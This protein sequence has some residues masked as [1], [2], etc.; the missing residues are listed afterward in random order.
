MD[1]FAWDNIDVIGI[2]K[3]NPHITAPS[4]ENREK[5]I[6][7]VA[8]K[9]R[10]SLN[11]IWSFCFSKNPLSSPTSF[12][13]TDYDVS[14]WETISVPSNWEFKGYGIPI[15]TNVKYPNSIS[16]KKIPSIDH[17]DNPTGCYKRKFNIPIEWIGRKLFINFD[18]VKSAFYLWING[19]E[20]GYS[21]GSMTPSEFDIT[22]YIHE[23]ENDVS[24]E[25]FKYCD[26][27]YL[28]DQ[29]M[30]RLSGIFRD[31]YLSSKPTTE[32]WDVY[33]HSDLDSD[34]K[35]AVLYIDTKI[36]NYCEATNSKIILNIELLDDSF[37]L[38]EKYLVEDVSINNN[39]QN[40]MIQ[41]KVNNPHKWSHEKPYLYNILFE[42][43]NSNGEVIDLKAIKF[44][45]RKI[46]IKNSKLYLN[47]K[48]IL[49]KGVNRHEFDHLNGHA[50][51]KET[52][53][54]DILL[55]KK[56]NVN[57]IRTSHYPNQEVFYDLCD[58]YG[59]LV[60]DECD[61]ETHELRGKIPAS[62]SEWIKPCVDRLQ[63]M[64]HRDKNHACIIFWSLGNE[65]GY[66]TVFKKMKEAALEIDKTRPI[67]YEGDHIL[68]ISDVFSMMYAPVELVEK[69]GQGKDVRA[70]TGEN[71]NLFGK[72][73]SFEKYKD[74]PFILC[75]YAHCMGNSLGNF[76]DYME[77][78]LKYDRCIGGFIWDFADQSIL[79]KN[80]DNI[81]IWAYGGDFGDT[82]NDG[83]FC[84]NGIFCADR[85][86]HPAAFEVKKVYQSILSELI[87]KNDRAINDNMVEIRI[88]NNYC[89]TDLS[90]FQFE[91]EI[92]EDGNTI[93]N[94]E[95]DS[96]D[97]EPQESTIIK[98]PVNG[99]ELLN[100]KEYHLTI[101]YLYYQNTSWCNSGH[102]VACD[103]FIIKE[104]EILSNPINDMG[105]TP[106]DKKIFINKDESNLEIS[107][108]NFFVSFNK[109]TGYITSLK[110]NDIEM[111]MSPLQP[112]LWRATIDNDNNY[113]WK[114]NFPILE[115]FKFEEKWKRA[116][117]K[118]RLKS[119][120]VYSEDSSITIK[121]KYIV[122]HVKETLDIVYKINESGKI[123]VDFKMIPKIDAERLGMQFEVPLPLNNM[124]WFGRGPWESYID[125]KESALVGIYT[126]KSEGFVH[127][128]L[129]PQE[130]G[131]R[132]DVRWVRITDQIGEG[133][134]IIDLTGQYLNASM[135]PY[136]MQDLHEC[137]HIHELPRRPYNTV[138]IDL[139]QRGV[140][141]DL[142]ACAALKEKYKMKKGKKYIY[143]FSIEYCKEGIL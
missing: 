44:G 125:R 133:I 93:F 140:G 101:K 137:S 3:E 104:K 26:G 38:I 135:W 59:M 53:E 100:D 143:S 94:G 55:L 65:A 121:T 71:H 102:E 31:V 117:D 33:C 134:K 50:I 11:G 37:N 74:M 141:G 116:N 77:A 25:V 10:L 60:M 114:S 15:Y 118:I 24:V 61:L 130:N 1:R 21:Q 92:L 34:Y 7:N 17:N 40:N 64:V 41:I 90:K 42:L 14:N 124:T 73:V 113:L 89:F 46:E 119:F 63:R 95:I 72:K 82:P 123:I 13:N 85:T 51:S 39:F 32:I 36:R 45:F 8:S 128:Y 88:S 142:P 29:D 131:N 87:I 70:G 52:I 58:K 120:D 122:S 18:G 75:E 106:T 91:Y 48:S 2:N 16:T 108:S 76:K 96:I 49:I 19:N 86:P 68:D 20:V 66:G 103:Q 80:D 28:E 97:L 126:G 12:F 22:N 27:S 79:K 132:T 107:N 56:Y 78:F 54:K 4:Y 98:I 136:S 30:W 62:R 83:N 111:L 57:A 67:H 110:Y 112:N 9:W 127:N 5:I 109:K 81:D 138:N 115:N 6:H 105:T 84:G 35:D 129:K 139:G 43:K 99:I 47:G 69:I 23:G